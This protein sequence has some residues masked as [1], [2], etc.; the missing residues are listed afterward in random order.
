VPKRD[1]GRGSRPSGMEMSGRPAR[2]QPA[3]SRLAEDTTAGRKSEPT[4][5]AAR[6]VGGEN[7]GRAYYTASAEPRFGPFLAIQNRCFVGVIFVGDGMRHFRSP[8]PLG[9]GQRGGQ[10]S[11]PFRCGRRPRRNGKGFRSA[12]ADPA[13]KGL[14]YGKR[15]A[16]SHPLSRSNLQLLTRRPH[17][18]SPGALFLLT[19]PGSGFRLDGADHFRHFLVSG[20]CFHSSRDDGLRASLAE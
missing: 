7:G 14:G 11:F 20:R 17:L 16:R 9:L 13:L 10:F 8:V 6:S 2:W 15:I 4:A 3:Q 5:A 18:P 12:M 19:A 1:I